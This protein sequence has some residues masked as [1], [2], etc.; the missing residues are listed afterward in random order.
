M[1][2]RSSALALVASRRVGLSRPGRPCPGKVERPTTEA[3][4]TRTALRPTSPSSC[5][6]ARLRPHPSRP[7]ATNGA[8]PPCSQCLT[9]FVMFGPFT[10]LAPSFPA[11]TP[12]TEQRFDQARQTFV[13]IVVEA[14][15]VGVPAAQ[16]APGST[17]SPAY[18]RV[19]AR[20]DCL[21]P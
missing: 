10:S 18:V 8:G 9:A 4:L 5:R 3:T 1:I 16:A 12:E 7:G 20:A 11:V 6:Y 2:L 15:R 17:V 13:D 14:L 19:I 21:P